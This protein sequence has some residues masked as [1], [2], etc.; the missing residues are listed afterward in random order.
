MTSRKSG[1]SEILKMLNLMQPEEAHGLIKKIKDE[2]PGLAQYL[3]ENIIQLQDIE[4]LTPSMLTTL[5][6]EIS[7]KDLAYA[8]KGQKSDSTFIFLS[9]QISQNNREE[10]QEYYQKTQVRKKEVLDSQQKII[11]KIKQLQDEGK[12]ILHPS[13]NDQWV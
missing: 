5:I 2:N 13:K 11:K 10:L 1:P 7:I 6:A 12:I 3:E 9:G 4:N 8:L